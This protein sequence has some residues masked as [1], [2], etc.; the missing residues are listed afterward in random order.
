MLRGPDMARIRS[1]VSAASTRRTSISPTMARIGPTSW[2]RTYRAVA[3]AKAV[4]TLRPAA[5][6][7]P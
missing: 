6:P 2:M 1:A 3:T 7:R 4:T 5:E